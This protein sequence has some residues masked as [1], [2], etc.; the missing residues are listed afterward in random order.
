MAMD[1][2]V[3]A[4]YACDPGMSR[5]RLHSEPASESRSAFRRDPNEKPL[6]LVG[7]NVY[8]LFGDWGT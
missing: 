2:I 4:P 3:R 5:G 8:T 1:G 7:H 6:L